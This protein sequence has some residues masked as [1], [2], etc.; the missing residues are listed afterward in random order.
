MRKILLFILFLPRHWTAKDF[1]HYSSRWQRIF[2]HIV[3]LMMQLFSALISNIKHNNSWYLIYPFCLQQKQRCIALEEQL[4]EL[5]V[6]ALEDCSHT[7][8]SNSNTANNT[9]NGSL[10]SPLDHSPCSCA[11]LSSLLIYFVLF[12][13]ISF[14]S[15]VLRLH[16]KVI[17]YSNADFSFIGSHSEESVDL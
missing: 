14:P 15:L 7:E 16:E 10:A 17:V 8:S 11:H 5:M 4:V 1:F 12:Q 13:L 6:S 2:F 3:L 9:T